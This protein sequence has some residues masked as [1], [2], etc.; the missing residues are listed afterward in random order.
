MKKKK[1]KKLLKA[2]QSQI[3]AAAPDA[4]L[5]IRDWLPTHQTILA[6]K[7]YKPQTLRNRTTCV[8]HVHRLWG[9]RPLRA[10]RAHEINTALRDGFIP[11]RLGTAIRILAELR[12]IYTGAIANGEADA[13][14]AMLVKLPHAKIKRQRLR[15]ETWDS[16]GQL[17]RTC[18]Q[19]WVLAMLLLALVIG[20]RRADLA[21]A[22]FTD[23]VDGHLQ[24]EQQKEAGKG[25]GARV[26]IPL[27]LRLDVIGMTLSDVIEFC[28]TVGKPGEHLLR[29]AGGKGIEVSSLSNRFGETIAAVLADADPGPRKRPS[30]HEVRSLSAR[31]Y[32]AQGMPAATVQTLLG[33]KD[34]EMT[35]LYLDDRGLTAREYKRVIL[36][37]QTD[38]ATQQAQQTNEPVTA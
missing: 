38:A 4:G 5:A 14:P 28:R 13:N 31:M 26:A 27:A 29:T 16:M 33:H 6:E 11:E 23:V 8:G 2:L 25:Y 32:M 3:A 37:N 15:F 17:A 1:L 36:P 21:K 12:S 19:R 9:A 35:E 24:I 20:Q 18:R 30:L 10:L 34:A 22:K 7:G